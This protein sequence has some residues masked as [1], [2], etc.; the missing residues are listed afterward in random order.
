MFLK[1]WEDLPLVMQNEHVRPYYDS[2]QKKNNGK[3]NLNDK[4]W[5]SLNELWK[6]DELYC[7]N[8]K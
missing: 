3:T 2:L 5:K 8:G 6:L 7:I 4:Q 1:K